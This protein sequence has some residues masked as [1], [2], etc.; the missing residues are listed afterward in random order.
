MPHR[1]LSYFPVPA[2]HARSLE[3]H[4]NIHEMH[5]V[6]I[7]VSAV[8]HLPC[9]LSVCELMLVNVW[10][11]EFALRHIILVLLHV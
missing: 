1:A 2:I 10:H 5:I 7:A 8:D 11:L 6:R 3:M 4:Q 9:A